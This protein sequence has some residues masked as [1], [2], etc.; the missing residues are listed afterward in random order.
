MRR[1][2]GSAS[3]GRRLRCGRGRRPRR[4]GGRRHDGHR[5]RRAPVR[6]FEAPD[7]RFPLRGR[8][9]AR[10]GPAEQGRR[11]GRNYADH[12][13][14][15]GDEVPAE[16]VIF[17]KPSTS[18]VGP[19]DPIRYPTLSEQVHHEA[20]L[21]V[22]IG[23][24]C[25]EVPIERVLEVVLG[26]TCAND[27]TAR[28]LQRTDAQWAPR[29]GLRQLLPARSVDRD[30]PRPADLRDRLPRQRRAAA[31]RRAPRCSSARVASSSRTS[32]R[33]DAAA[34]RRDPHRHAGRCRPDRRRATRCPWRSRASA[35]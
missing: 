33:D 30:R 27:V 13:K 20:E 24:L 21:A 8:T 11:L 22:V 6:A 32:P 3:T 28:D 2:P 26:Y 23:R 31:G 25:S 14:E 15:M 5:D 9:P 12:A 10:A 19:G 29:Q 4:G 35:R 17:L 18:V 7:P 34:R 1:S 16:P